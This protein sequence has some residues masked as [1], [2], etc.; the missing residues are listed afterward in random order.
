MPPEERHTSEV[1]VF[2]VIGTGSQILRDIGVGKMRLLS[3]PTRFNAI[4]GFHLEVV[5]FVENDSG[6]QDTGS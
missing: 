4:S 6:N 2:R 1:G 5:E 3:S